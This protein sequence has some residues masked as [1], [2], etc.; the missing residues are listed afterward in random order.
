V[1]IIPELGIDQVG[2]LARPPMDLDDFGAF[3]VTEVRP[4]ASLVNTRERFEGVQGASMDVEVVR[5]DLALGRAL[6]RRV[7]GSR[8]PGLEEQGVGSLA[9]FRVGAKKGPHVPLERAG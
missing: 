5:Q 8:V 1:R 2:E 9:G 7:D 6:A 3:H 4:A